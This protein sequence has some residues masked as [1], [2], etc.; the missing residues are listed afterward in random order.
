MSTT[1][2]R[3]PVSGA[4]GGMRK[5]PKPGERNWASAEEDA[6][7]DAARAVKTSSGKYKQE[8]LPGEE[9]E[10]TYLAV[11]TKDGTYHLGDADSVPSH[12]QLAEA[13]GINPL[14]IKDA[15]YWEFGRYEPA[16]DSQIFMWADDAIKSSKKVISRDGGWEYFSLDLP[17]EDRSYYKKA[18][19]PA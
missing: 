6:L 19:R 10:N 8:K 18:H 7:F 5:E 17:G 4:Q 11:G 13:K 9:D 14:D 16:D 1:D 2:P 3:V 15:G 12:S